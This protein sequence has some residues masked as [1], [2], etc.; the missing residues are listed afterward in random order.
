MLV[1]AA[2]SRCGRFEM[3]LWVRAVIDA[4][5]KARGRV[6][7]ARVACTRPVPAVAGAHL[8]KRC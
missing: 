8:L 4:A 5:V 7:D 1:Q 3:L 6:D 2:G